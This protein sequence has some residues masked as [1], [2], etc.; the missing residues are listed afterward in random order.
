MEI[1]PSSKS[2]LGPRIGPSSKSIFEPEIV[3][4]SKL[5]LYLQVDQ[6]GWSAL[7]KYTDKGKISMVTTTRYFTKIFILLHS[8]TFTI[9]QRGD[10]QGKGQGLESI[11]GGD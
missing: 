7:A 9:S 6:A 4:S 3:P 2:L 1:A 11:M 5:F 8:T 10:D